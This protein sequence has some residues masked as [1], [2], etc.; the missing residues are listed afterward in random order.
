M[1]CPHLGL[2][3]ENYPEQVWKKTE[4]RERFKKK[5]KLR[6]CGHDVLYLTRLGDEK[7]SMSGRNRGGKEERVSETHITCLNDPN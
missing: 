6:L 7:G 4:A 5:K 2:S 3:G 1:Q